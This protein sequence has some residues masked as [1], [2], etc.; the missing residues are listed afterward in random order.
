MLLYKTI[1]HCNKVQ[2]RADRDSVIFYKN[3]NKGFKFTNKSSKILA[4]I[5]RIM[6]NFITQN[7]IL[8]IRTSL[9]KDIQVAYIIL[10]QIWI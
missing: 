8:T 3:Q 4:S 2:R 10:L 7:I 5:I 1:D 6:P 9:S